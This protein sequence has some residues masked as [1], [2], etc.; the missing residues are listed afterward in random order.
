MNSSL[1]TNLMYRIIL[2]ET[3]PQPKKSMICCR[4]M[5]TVGGGCAGSAGSTSAFHAGTALEPP[6]KLRRFGAVM[7]GARGLLPEP[8]SDA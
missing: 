8:R 4:L 6:V 3:T 2:S 5:A 7:V 1:V